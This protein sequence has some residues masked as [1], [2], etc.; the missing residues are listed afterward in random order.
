MYRDSQVR[1]DY[2]RELRER[3]R[4]FNMVQEL[5]GNIRVFCRCDTPHNRYMCC[6]FVSNQHILMCV[7]HK[8]LYCERAQ[9]SQPKRC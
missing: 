4:L 5:R 6:F 2:A 7:D 1:R 3:K 8:Q 9:W